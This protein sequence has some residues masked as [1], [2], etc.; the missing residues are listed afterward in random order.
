[1]VEEK[2]PVRID[3][4]EREYTLDWLTALSPI[5]LIAVLYYRWAAVGVVL[6]ATAGY[7]TAA[8]LL[9]WAG[10]LTCRIAPAVTA[11][12]LVAFCLPATTPLWASALAGAIAAPLAA[13]PGAL[14]RIKPTWPISRPLLCPA[15]V[16]YL[17]VRL[18]FPAYTTGY[19]LPV[20]WA[21]LDSVSSATP[22]TGLGEPL[23][24]GDGVRLLLGVHAGSIGG[25]CVP[26]I[27]LA[28]VYLLLRRRL[29][30]IVPGVMLATVAL[31]SWIVW[32]APLYGL[33]AGGTVLAAVLVAD[34][35]YAPV[36]YGEQAV[37]GVVAGGAT[38]LLR[39][40]A[41]MDGAAVGVLL[42]GALAPVY[43]GFLRWSGIALRKGWHYTRIGSV[44]FW[45]R[46]L[47][48]FAR[49]TWQGMQIAWRYICVGAVWFW[50]RALV[51]FGRLL[52][53]ETRRLWRFLQQ[54]CRNFAKSKK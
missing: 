22:L 14:A 9:Q 51:P 35:M 50:T 31:L 34:R 49:L 20:Q 46:A 42:A 8:V 13:L 47:V 2:T 28:G 33:L 52:W 1:M 54:K 53:R 15:L 11:G 3:L 37:A 44:W 41:G 21:A 24:A 23:S 7:L 5:L 18:V 12:M 6:M 32:G 36:S 19:T 29:R 39:G 16:G 4:Q 26:V 10:L 40:I 17:L 25:G 43:G 48:P 27:L 30:L 45:T 38:V